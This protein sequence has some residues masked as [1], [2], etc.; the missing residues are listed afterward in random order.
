MQHHR[1]PNQGTVASLKSNV[2]ATLCN[3]KVTVYEIP[4]I[5]EHFGRSEYFN[6]WI[7]CVITKIY[8]CKFLGWIQSSIKD[9]DI[10]DQIDVNY[11]EERTSFESRYFVITSAFEILIEEKL[12][13]AQ[14]AHVFQSLHYI[15]EDTSIIQGT[16]LANDCLKLPRI[17][18][19]TFSGKYDE[20]MSFRNTFHR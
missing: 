18:L 11:K 6:N 4:N 5:C 7:T 3:D 19:L 8:Y 14:S 9:L 1:H 20:W 13:V 10:G 17:T 2:E 16:S 15:R 12:L